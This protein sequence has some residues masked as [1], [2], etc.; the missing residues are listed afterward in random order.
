MTDIDNV[1]TIVTTATRAA[2]GQLLEVGHVY[3]FSTPGGVQRVDLTGEEYKDQ[4]SR[5]TGTTVVRDSAA[6]LAYYG[7]HHDANTEVY[8]DVEGLSVTAVLDANTADSARWGGHRLT[9]GLRT[10]KA[11]REWTGSSGKLMTQ[12]DF[13]EFLEAH[14]PDLVDPD[15]A[16]MLEIAQS[17]KASTKGQFESG[18]RLQS[19]ARRLVF[20]EETTAKAGSRGQLDIPEVFKIAVVPFEGAIRYSVNA[21]LKYR[22]NR[23]ELT[24][25]YLLEQPEERVAAAFEEVVGLI[26]EGV[27]TPILNGTPA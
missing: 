24:I 8:S 13:A 7:K 23:N 6:F 21:R 11:W 1:Q 4:P 2:A 27:D 12:D 25:G 17:I 9:L 3:A 14:L 26:A 18:S 20:T 15:A 10:T 5:K 19:G 22:I 16:T